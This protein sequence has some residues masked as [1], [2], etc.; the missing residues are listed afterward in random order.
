[1]VKNRIIST[2]LAVLM[3]LSAF[4]MM[5]SANDAAEGPVYT[6]N[7]TSA[8]PT[9]WYFSGKPVIKDETKDVATY[10][11][12]TEADVIVETPQ[13]KLSLMDLRLEKDGYRLYV[14]A[15]SGEVAVECIASGEILFS[16]PYD[17]YKDK[18][19]TE[20]IKSQLLSQLKVNFTN[21]ATDEE[22]DYWS[23]EWAAS[24]GQI[25][26]KNI[27]N[28]IRV[29]YT[30]GR[31][32]SKYLVP[33][34]I[35]K[36][37]FESK[38]YNAVKETMTNDEDGF[39]KADKELLDDKLGEWGFYQ[40][41]DPSAESVQS[42]IAEMHKSF[43]ITKKMPIYVLDPTTSNAEKA[44][45]E[46]FIKTYA[47]DYSYDDLDE[48]HLKVEWESEDDNP[49]LF[50]MALEYTLDNMGVS[51]RLPANGIRFAE[52]LY[53]LNSIDILPYM[54][55]G[56]NP[57]SGYTF[58]PD[59]SGTLFDFEDTA[60]LGVSTNVQGKIY[61]VD[62]AYHDITGTHQETI[63]YPV[64]GIYENEELIVKQEKPETDE[65][66]EEETVK[67]PVETYYKERGF[68]A[69]V[70][71]GDALME[72]AAY[73][74]IIP[75]NYNTVKMTV[76]PRPNDTYN[77]ADAISVGQNDTWTVVSA[78][79]YT[80]SY[81]VRYIMLTSDEVAAEKGL[82]DTYDTSYVG[83]AKAYRDYLIN[84]GVL[85]KLTSEDVKS[86][87]PLYIETFG[88]M[89]TTERFLSIP[90]TVMTPLT[91]FADINT[92]Y[93]EFAAKGINNINFIMTGYT[94]G[95]LTEPRAPYNLKWE[96]AVEEGG[97]DFEELTAAA[98]E[99]GF[100]LFPDFDFAFTKTNMLFDG[101]NL[102]NHAVKTID[103]RYSSKR[104]YSATKQ[105]YISYYELALSPAYFSHFY[106]KFTQKYLE[107]NPIGISVSTLGSYLNSDFD[108]DEPYN[109]SDSR[110]FTERAFQYIRENYN[111]VMTA[112][113]NAF[114]W[115]YV[116]YIT[117]IALDSSRFAESSAAVPF[118]AI[119]LHGYVEYTGTAINMEGNMEYS[120]LK[121]LESGAS[122]NFILSYQ[123]TDNLK[124]DMLLS[125]YYS[126]RYDI[127]FNDVVSLYS[128][129]NGLLKD[130]QTSTIETHK[131]LEG[132]RIPDADELEEDL[133]NAVEEAIKNEETLSAAK[134]EELRKQL[135]EARRLILDRIPALNEAL[136]A[137][138]GNSNLAENITAIKDLSENLDDLLKAQKTFDAAQADN[139]AV[140]ADPNA[141]QQDKDAAKN[142]YDTAKAALEAA[143]A[144]GSAEYIL[145]RIYR[146]ANTSIADARALIAD[147]E[148]AVAGL[149]L[150]EKEGAYTDD[151]RN[152][153]KTILDNNNIAYEAI[154]G[155]G[156]SAT[157]SK[158]AEILAL[159]KAAFA[160]YAEANK[161]DA[162]EAP[163]EIN[164][165]KD[166]EYVPEEEEKEESKEENKTE[167][168]F[169]K[170]E[171]DK[172]KIVYMEY[173]N[174][175]NRNVTAFILNFNN[176]AVTVTADNGITYTLE[177]YGYIVIKSTNA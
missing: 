112:G 75:H 117:D 147:Y 150:L 21:I 32:Q 23:Y 145:D 100:Q 99:K 131:F 52:S 102:K 121:A 79:K 58:F 109:R 90:F 111:K 85:N 167:E 160:K 11:E 59:G 84:K 48:D 13:D 95:G 174:S 22:E 146:L 132:T 108:E 65:D 93:D 86:D 107:Y 106:E 155:K 36:S 118:L 142:A 114:T 161:G 156:V 164:G 24:R 129:L 35:E 81:K 130:L 88:A 53:R 12:D 56:E 87:I 41:K 98:R 89:E 69:I 62:Y 127:W 38:L 137:D 29:E 173:V 149:A 61:G 119:V 30:I 9:Y 162:A 8:K 123:N 31:E 5:V 154:S 20:D 15:Y 78:R 14:D 96:K 135:H 34:R 152:E 158:E 136:K 141:T 26:V 163:T 94:K 82:T 49:P 28:G 71:E 17:V 140:L 101:V 170:Y 57:N 148:K 7:T 177:A 91:T 54:G 70:E 55:A 27:K 171:S 39:T 72:L 139:D 138:D 115:K 175:D 143:S 1:M 110:D 159:A 120:L 18:D 64:F 3:L 125:H 76:K 97:M 45:L 43:P 80:G 50:K 83:M 104:E 166:Y 77:V 144:N 128:E 66:E 46:Q 16:N 47:P 60:A 40:L 168:T 126:I 25:I 122:L 113:G 153:L 157:E 133:K 44:R 124:D 6:K 165:F 68:V 37:S 176:Y 33:E 63:R 92:M 19:A 67:T 4:T 103:D 169:N 134:A 42:I 51:V 10:I 116:D 151:H 74:P 73:H 105:T 2:L 172:N